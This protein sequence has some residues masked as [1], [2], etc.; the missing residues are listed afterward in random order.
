M[1]LGDDV[2]EVD[3]DLT[4]EKYQTAKAFLQRVVSELA[5]EHG[6]ALN[7]LINEGARD[8][9]VLAS[10][11]VARDYIGILR[12]SIENAKEQN[13]S[14]VTVAAV[15]QASGEYESTKRDEFQRDVIDGQDALQKEFENIKAFCFDKEVNKNCFTVEKDLGG[16]QY[17]MVKE[18]VDLRLVHAIKS[19]VTV[20]HR[21]GRIYE[22]Y[23]LDLSQYAGERKRRNFEILEFWRRED[24][25]KLRLAS[26]IYAEAAGG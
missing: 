14:Q 3:L 4:L 24:E 15:N 17:R 10:G 1:K 9:L 11:G 8:R 19:R 2:D 5:Q 18:L 6:I 23:M 26:L 21:P 20:R 16:E 25:E 22:A 12:I 13:L 7:E